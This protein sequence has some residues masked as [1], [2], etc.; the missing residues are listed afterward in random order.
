MVSD[1]IIDD[2][3]EWSSKLP[4]LRIKMHSGNLRLPSHAEATIHPKE[5]TAMILHQIEQEMLRQKDQWDDQIDVSYPPPHC[6]GDFMTYIIMQ[7]LYQPT[8]VPYTQHLFKYILPSKPV[9]QSSHMDEEEEVPCAICL[10]CARGG[11]WFID[12]QLQTSR[13]TL[14]AME[15]SHIFSFRCCCLHKGDFYDDGKCDARESCDTRESH[16]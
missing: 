4:G 16:T 10:H 8:P 13:T 14:T 3:I 9:L 6:Q 12:G 11:H 1:M 2:I 15:A 5:H 7:N